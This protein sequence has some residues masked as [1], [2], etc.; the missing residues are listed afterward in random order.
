MTGC[1]LCERPLCDV[2]H[3]RDGF[4]YC[5]RTKFVY[6]VDAKG[7]AIDVTA[8]NKSGPTLTRTVVSKVG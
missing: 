2:E 4:L 3:L 1:A 7:K 5:G 8:T 6:R